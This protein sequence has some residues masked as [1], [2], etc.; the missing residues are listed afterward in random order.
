MRKNNNELTIWKFDRI[1]NEMYINS[2]IK[3]ILN[4]NKSVINTEKVLICEK[5]NMEQIEEKEIKKISIPHKDL[6]EIK[7]LYLIHL[8]ISKSLLHNNV[9]R[10]NSK[11]LKNILGDY[12]YDMLYNLKKMNLISI[13]NEYEVGKQC[14]VIS[15][16][17]FN[18]TREKT[19]NRKILSYKDKLQKL[20]FENNNSLSKEGN[21]SYIYDE[22]F[23]SKYNS[24][25]SKLTFSNKIAAIAEINNLNLNDSKYKYNIARINNIHY[26]E[27]KITSIDKNNRIYHILTNMP[28]VIKKYFNIKS[29]IDISNSHPLLYSS[30]IISEYNIDY[31][32][33]LVLNSI[34]IDTLYTFNKNNDITYR[35]VTKLLRK[36][37]KLNNIN[38][39]RN[40]PSDCLYYLYLVI[41]GKFWDFFLSLFEN[42]NRGEIKAKL[43]KEVL[44]SHTIRI[45][46]EKKYGTIFV[47]YFKNVWSIL[48]KQKR[49]KN[50]DL[51][52]NRMM[53]LESQL[54]GK[55]LHRCFQKDYKVINIHDAILVLNVKENANISHENIVKIIKD[56]YSEA[57]LLPTVSIDEY[58]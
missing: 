1:N 44:Y 54:I 27:K 43:F 47:K 38:N 45:S 33:L 51:L 58:F 16:K 3:F 10:L 26:I 11:V 30:F 37:L 13:S 25:L 4:K 23:I 53:K 42:E 5:E 35:N 6:L 8:L 36:T 29:Q 31:N 50:S 21:T 22:K 55:I 39:N 34:N 48:R 28:K 56:V 49:I 40:I 12:V 19:I 46:K 32:F 20:L 52:A 2:H 18:F 41:K 14:R 57:N 15:L 9:I 24:V 7:Y 17:Y